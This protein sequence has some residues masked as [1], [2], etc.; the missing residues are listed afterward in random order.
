MEVSILYHM[1]YLLAYV[2]FPL[3]CL[4]IPKPFLVQGLS[5]KRICPIIC[6]MAF[7]DDPLL[8]NYSSQHQRLG[9]ADRQ[10]MTAFFFPCW[11]S[12]AFLHFHGHPFS[13]TPKQ[14]HQFQ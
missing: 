12:S 5:I 11:G 2:Y 9:S 10:D 4:I 13:L 3:C 1:E 7:K 14:N 6:Y 8:L